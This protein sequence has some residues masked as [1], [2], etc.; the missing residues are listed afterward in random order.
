MVSAGRVLDSPAVDI[1]PTNT[2][3]GY[4]IITSKGVVNAFGDAGHFGDP[5]KKN[6][7]LSLSAAASPRAPSLTSRHVTSKWASPP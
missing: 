5:L 4:W 2:G 1:E 6:A 3:G 7:H